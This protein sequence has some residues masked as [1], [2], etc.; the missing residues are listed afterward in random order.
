MI[1]RFNAAL[2]LCAAMAPGLFA[3]SLTTLFTFNAKNGSLPGS[4]V[5]AANGYLYG[6]TAGGGAHSAGTVFRVT[7][8]GTLTTLYA[9]CAQS[10]C[11]D[12]QS[13]VS[14]L[15]QAANGDLY[16]A[17]QTGGAYLNCYTPN[18]EHIGCGAIFK[19]TPS[20]AFTTVYSFCPHANCG[21]GSVP[22]AGLVQAANGDL[23]GTTSLGGGG[24][25]HTGCGTIFK[26]SPSGALKT[27]Y[28]FTCPLSGPCPDGALPFA[29]L[30][31]ATDGNLY[32]TTS[33]GGA[34]A[35]ARGT[36]FRVTPGGVLTTLYSFCAQTGCSD[37]EYPFA[38]LIQAADGNFYGT[39]SGGGAYGYGTVFKIT[40][41]GVLTTLHSFCAEAACADGAYPYTPLVQTAGGDLYGTTSNSGANG[42]G[43]DFGTIFKITPA[44]ALTT[45]Y[46]FCSL[47]KCADG[48]FPN[49]LIQAASGELYGTTVA[50]GVSTFACAYSSGGC[51]TIFSFSTANSPPAPR[52]P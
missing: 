19:I 14:G 38:P 13:P 43:T 11:P 8:G 49:G 47:A 30:I 3:Q 51:G 9:F 1:R 45:V 31:Q 29:S 6:T 5:Q 48:E 12:G 52:H 16:G 26:M 50:G 28:R 39:T 46:S 23:Y 33:G 18:G 24:C 17:T 32:G 41:S 4:L 10:G 42:N 15:V 40:P 2:L 25:A 22:V 27:L 35:T 34:T 20:G 44:G 7:P 37:G 21:D 36:V